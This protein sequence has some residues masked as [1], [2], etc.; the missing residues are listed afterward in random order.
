MPMSEQNT[1][2]TKE[3]LAT[4]KVAPRKPRIGDM[5]HYFKSGSNSQG[6]RELKPWA[7]IVTDDKPQGNFQPHD[8]A[9]TLKILAKLSGQVDDLRIG[10]QHSH[11]AMEGRW[12]HIPA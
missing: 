11:A 7:A 10:V 1:V 3:S 8:F 5:V 2:E 4:K 9:V 6:Q 12:S